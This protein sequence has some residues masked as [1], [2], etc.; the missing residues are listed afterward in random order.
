MDHMIVAPASLPA[1]FGR[2]REIL[3]EKHEPSV[4]VVLPSRPDRTRRAVECVAARFRDDGRGVIALG[5]D[6][7]AE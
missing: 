3:A 7:L 5:A 6:R 1:R 2:W 4:L